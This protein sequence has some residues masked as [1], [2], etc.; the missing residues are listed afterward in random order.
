[1][2][3]MDEMSVLTFRYMK[4]FAIVNL[5]G[6]EGGHCTMRLSFND[7]RHE[8]RALELWTAHG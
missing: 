4:W 2:H 3:R 8:Q 1:M 5:V 6:P 7:L